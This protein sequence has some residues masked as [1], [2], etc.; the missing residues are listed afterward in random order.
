MGFPQSL[1]ETEPVHL[2]AWEGLKMP[3]SQQ[4]GWLVSR[5]EVGEKHSPSS[6]PLSVCL[7]Y[8]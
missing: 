4:E 5:V 1:A 8:G 3:Q 7:A 6:N 2:G